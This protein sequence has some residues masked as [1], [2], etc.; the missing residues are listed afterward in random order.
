MLS[1]F[2]ER[3]I[4][5]ATGDN[6]SASTRAYLSPS[7]PPSDDSSSQDTKDTALKDAQRAP[8]KAA[9]KEEQQKFADTMGVLDSE[10]T[11]N[12]D[13]KRSIVCRQLILQI[14][15]FIKH[16]GDRLNTDDKAAFECLKHCNKNVQIIENAWK[17]GEDM[18]QVRLQL[19]SPFSEKDEGISMDSKK[20][21]PEAE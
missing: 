20:K 1:S 8:L 9:L 11:K 5:D 7:I 16:Q 3:G 14:L 17:D 19:S 4:L 6:F 12:S 2:G 10:T 13:E 18:T 21:K 15:N